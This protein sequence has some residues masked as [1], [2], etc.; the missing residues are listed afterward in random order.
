MKAVAELLDLSGKAA[1]VTGGAAGIGLGISRRLAEAGASVL[2]ADIDGEGARLAAKELSGE[3][4]RAEGMTADV[5]DEFDVRDVIDAAVHL[6]GRIDILVNNA[7]IYPNLP[8]GQ[9]EPDSFDRVVAVNLRGVYL[10]TKFAAEL[11]KKQGHGGRII[12]VTSID[13]LH[14]SMIG[15]AAY[16]ATKHGVWGFTKNA[17]AELAP[18]G[19]GVN[20]VAPGGVITPGT[21]DMIDEGAH[22]TGEARTGEARTGEAQ[23]AFLAKIPMRRM[24]EP[25]EIG[26]VVLFLASDMASYMTGS[27][28][29]VDG[30]A[31]LS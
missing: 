16:D 29:V 19:I 22:R 8:L 6:F 27:Q 28:V 7:G 1:I 17:A 30:G 15:L 13:A 24:G 9:L 21:Q 31:L 20:A 11:M 4:Y 2:I 25:D 10:F 26:K 12:N 23:A 5:A 14:P 18:H 3:G